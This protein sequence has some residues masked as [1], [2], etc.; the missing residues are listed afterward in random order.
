[1][2]P[3][4]RNE[5]RALRAEIEMIAVTPEAAGRPET[6]A[7]LDRAEQRGIATRTIEPQRCTEVAGTVTPSGLLAMVRWSPRIDPEPG[8]LV[9]ILRQRGIERLLALDA[10]TD[11]G[12][13]GTL[14][15]TAL[16]FGV[17]GVLFGRGSVDPTNPKVI[18]SSAGAILGV[19]LLV[20]TADLAGLVG[21]V[22]SAGWMIYR[23]EAAGGST[24]RPDHGAARWLLLLGSE[25]AG[26]GEGLS[27]VGTALTLPLTAGVDSLNVAVAG[28]ILLHVLTQGQRE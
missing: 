1:M 28:G 14:V 20:S 6:A 12:N 3:L 19:P 25:A 5:L 10:V 24:P 16:A 18:R 4:S 15:R 17:G 27:E 21:G 13:A 7:L 11:P 22:Q 9:D 26:V 23:A 8:E 2:N